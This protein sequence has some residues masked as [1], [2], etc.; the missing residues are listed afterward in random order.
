MARILVTVP[1]D[2]LEWKV[3]VT[4][5]ATSRKVSDW[6]DYCGYDDTP[7]EELAIDMAGDVRDFI[8]AVIDRPLRFRQQRRFLKPKFLL[9]WEQNGRWSSAVPLDDDSEP[10]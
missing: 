7:E 1:K 6:C 8:R 3:N 5:T 4:C 9:E 10:A 2:V